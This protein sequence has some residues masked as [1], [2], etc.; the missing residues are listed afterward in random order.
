[1]ADSTLDSE[2]LQLKDNWPGVADPGLSICKNPIDSAEHNV[3]IPAYPVGTK[4]QLRADGSVGKAGT[5]TL[6]YLPVGTQNAAAL[7]A[8]KTFC[9]LDDAAGTLAV[10][11]D[12][13]SC[14]NIG[15]SPLCVAL[16]AMTD[17]RY[18]WF[19]CAGVAPEQ[20]VSGMGGNYLTDSTVV[21]GLVSAGD[22]T[23]D[24]IGL[25]A[26]TETTFGLLPAGLAFAADV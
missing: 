11:N 3:A 21:A 19:W 14:V 15:G 16:S 22:L 18:G 2:L 26:Q 6:I 12:P 20:W 5:C 4:A 24:A 7:I 9:V 8:A 23:A 13:D 1:M 17:G 25:T 10:T